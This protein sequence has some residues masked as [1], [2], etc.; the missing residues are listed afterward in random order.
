M[1]PFEI[2]AN[3]LNTIAIVLA[4]RNSVQ[5]WWTG[6]AGCAVFGWVFFQARLYA[7]VT[8]MVFF[9]VTSV[10]GWW[11]WVRGGRGA[12]LPV[13]HIA[14]SHAAGLGLAGLA[15]TGGYGW[16]LHRFTDAYAPF[17]DSL[18]LAFS[19][20]GQFLMMGRR[21]ES[22]WCWLVVNTVAVP[23]YLSRDLHLTAAF[24]AAYWINAVIALRTWRRLAQQN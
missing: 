21:V 23:L 13:R 8:L 16:L 2:I 7:D 9:I 6:I 12:E 15:V 11:H 22:W 1:S 4:G 19:V 20:L 14:V 17:W 18:V 3:I 10:V 24:Y 5:T